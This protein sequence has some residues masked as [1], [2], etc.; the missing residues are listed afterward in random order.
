M[1]IRRSTLVVKKARASIYPDFISQSI[2]TV[3][4]KYLRKAGITNCFIDLDGTVVSRGTFE[5]DPGIKQALKNSGLKIHIATNRPK[6]R[7]LKTLKEDLNASSVIHPVGLYGKP[8]RR[9]YVHAL[10]LLN[11]KSR[12][13]VMI[14]D[15]YIQDILGAN[16]A[17]IYSL[18]VYKL[19]PSKGKADELLSGYE[20]K[21]TE[22]IL[23]KYTDSSVK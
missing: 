5:V 12:E 7:S 1:R 9:Y 17:G 20:K 22:Y 19:G 21:I 23:P 8:S 6:S 16:R 18:L 11:L 13:V 2:K 10:K 15:R 14:G 4:F 3:D